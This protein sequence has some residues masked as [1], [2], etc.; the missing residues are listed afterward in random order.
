MPGQK[1]KFSRLRT[2]IKAI[3][4]NGIPQKWSYDIEGEL[5]IKPGEVPHYYKGLGT[6]QK[7]QLDYIIQK[8]GFENMIENYEFDNPQ[9]LKEFLSSEDSDKRK[10]YIRHHNFSIAKV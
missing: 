6:W 2:P 8:E 4:K 5:E 7:E 9:I 10:E 3:L 1:S